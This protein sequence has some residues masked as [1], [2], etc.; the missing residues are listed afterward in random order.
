MKATLLAL[1]FVTACTAPRIGAG[2]HVGPG[3]MTLVPRISGGIGAAWIGLS[4]YP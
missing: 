4:G 3:G 1:A 2:L